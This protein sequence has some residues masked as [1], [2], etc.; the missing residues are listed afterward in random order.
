MDDHVVGPLEE[1]GVDGADWTQVARGEA[2]GKEGSV[3]L[4]NPDVMILP[5]QFAAELVEAGARGHC[6]GDTNDPGIGLS[7]AEQEAAEDILPST[8]RTRRTRSEIIAG[9]WVEGARAVELLWVAE[10]GG[11]SASL[12]GADMEDD[13]AR[14][15]LAEAEVTLEGLEIM[16]VDRADVAKA[17]LL[18]EGAIASEEV[19]NL[20]LQGTPKVEHATA[21]V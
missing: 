18:E 12:L 10:G 11:Q 16:A 13:G 7:F 9:L 6:G 8:G 2:R 1:G 19:L 14:G 21:P 5:R 20:S 3:L 15:I 4:G 17:E